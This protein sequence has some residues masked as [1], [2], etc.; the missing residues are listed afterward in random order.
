MTKL[1]DEYEQALANVKRLEEDGQTDTYWH[2]KA[3]RLA[4]ALQG[5]R[6]KDKKS[7]VKD[8]TSTE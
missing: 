3:A 1:K 7:E 4:A 6:V 8:G 2:K 5:A